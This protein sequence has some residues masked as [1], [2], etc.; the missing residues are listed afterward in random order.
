ML[1]RLLDLKFCVECDKVT[2]VER[3]VDLLFLI[4]VDH[5]HSPTLSLNLAVTQIDLDSALDQCSTWTASKLP[6]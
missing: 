1:Y 2:V 4:F 5:H 6:T 3:G